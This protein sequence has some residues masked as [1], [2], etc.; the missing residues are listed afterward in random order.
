MRSLLRLIPYLRTYRRTLLLGVLTVVL[1]NLFFVAQPR[2]I[3]LAVDKLKIGLETRQIDSAGL[4]GYAGI[5]VGLSLVAGIFTF[6]TRQTIIVVSRHIE[7]DLRNDFLKHIQTL[8]LSY[9]QNT[10][11]GDLMAHATNDIGAVRNALGPGIMYPTDTLMTFTMALA[12]MLSA[13]WGLTLLALI[14]LP[15]V[16]YAVYRL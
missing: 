12:M 4:L 16:S 10:S 15:F 2:L 3:G 6:L 1:S 5:I 14:P 11:T 8:P 9:F 7:Y 13:D